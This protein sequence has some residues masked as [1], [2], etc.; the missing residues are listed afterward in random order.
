[1]VARRLREAGHAA[2]VVGGAVR[3]LLAGRQPG[4]WDLATS[5]RPEVMRALFTG[6]RVIDVGARHGTLGV[7]PTP[8]PG[9]A[10]PVPR[11]VQVTTF[12]VEGPYGDRRHPDYVRFVATLYEDLARRDFTVNALALDPFSGELHDPYRGVADLERGLVRAVGD[13]E[14]RFREDALRPLRA[15]RLVAEHGWEIEGDTAR[16]IRTCVGLVAHV[17]RERVRVELERI[18]PAPHAGLALALMAGY[19]LLGVLFPGTDF[20][21]VPWEAIDRLPPRVAVRLGALLR[22]ARA[23]A[24]PL[25]ARWGFPAREAEHAVALAT[26]RVDAG[27]LAGSPL[28]R[29]RWMAQVGRER[30]R[31]LALVVRELEPAWGEAFYREV[32]RDLERGLPLTVEE[33]PV[34][35]HDVMEA[36]GLTPGPEVGAVLRELLEAVWRDPSLCHR[37]ALLSLMRRRL[38]GSAS[39]QGGP[40]GGPTGGSR[41]AG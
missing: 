20:S 26:T 16:A 40:G 6:W 37:A 38:P 3:D 22:I 11:V 8:W 34:S 39:G 17:A 10:P 5:A 9:G 31:D 2:F 14:A 1:M 25:V 23:P 36:L 29:R 12:R 32:S 30:A 35:G 7:V 41:R 18:L 19:G 15:F 21:R 4:D 24:R 33:L 28:A 13:A 27:L